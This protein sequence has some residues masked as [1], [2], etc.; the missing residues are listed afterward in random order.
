M[1]LVNSDPVIVRLAHNWMRKLSTKPPIYSLQYHADHDPDK[2]KNFWRSYLDIEAL[3]IKLIRKSNSGQLSGRQFRSAHGLLT[4][5]ICDTY[6]RA[7]LQAWM[8]IVKSQW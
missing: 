2:L 7:R 5:L 4:V 3:P 8:D 1:S 6:F